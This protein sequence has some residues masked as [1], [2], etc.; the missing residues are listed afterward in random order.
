MRYLPSLVVA[1]TNSPD[2]FQC[3][4]PLLTLSKVHVDYD[5]R[6]SQE[7]FGR[8][9]KALDGNGRPVLFIRKVRMNAANQ[10]PED[11]ARKLGNPQ[12]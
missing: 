2:P 1:P 12:G 7:R 5:S 6:F 9:L 4:I 10:V 8:L 3:G 11:T